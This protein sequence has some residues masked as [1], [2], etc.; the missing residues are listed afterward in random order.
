MTKLNLVRGMLTIIQMKRVTNTTFSR[1][2]ILLKRRRGRHEIYTR[3]FHSHLNLLN[4]I[5]NYFTANLS[6][7]SVQIARLELPSILL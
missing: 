2:L 1:M 4:Y 6:T 5:S 3:C 7:F